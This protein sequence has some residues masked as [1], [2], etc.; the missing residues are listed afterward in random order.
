M[1]IET[2]SFGC[3][4]NA[5]EAD[6][7][8]IQAQAA[9]LSDL[10]IVNSC[11]VTAMAVRQTGQAIRRAARARPGRRVLVTGCAAQTEPGRFAAM[12]EVSTVLGNAEKMRPETWDRLADPARRPRVEVGDIMRDEAPPAP[13]VSTD[14]VRAVLQVQTGCDHRCTF[15]AIPFG[16]GNARS[17]APDAVVAAAGALVAAGT[18]EIVLTGVD[19]TSYGADL[20]E[21]WRLGRL[22]RRLLRALPDLERL[23]LSSIDG[24]EADPDLWRAL[25]EEPRLMPHLHLSLQAGDDMVLTRMK[26]RHRRADAIAFCER[27]RALRPDIVLG[28]D[29]IAGFPTETEAMFARSLDLVEEC[30]LAQLHVFPYSPRPGTPAARMPPVHPTAVAERAARLRAAGAAAFRSR[31][32]REH[33][34]RVRVLAE[35]RDAGRAENFLPV[36]LSAPAIRGGTVE[37]TVASDDGRRLLA[38]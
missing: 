30:G 7:M 17:I 36:A 14:R 22:V 4:L 23:R 9:G 24:I 1:T 37:V 34:R 28:A 20:A 16:R 32:A 11:A 12:P 26:R 13:A 8:R 38:A 33:G 31:L 29:L 18:R 19:L 3:R 10:L 6:T 25:A 27:V 21:G 5:A 15:C 2:L 35:S